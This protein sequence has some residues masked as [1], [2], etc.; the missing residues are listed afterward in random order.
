VAID[1]TETFRDDV[2][3]TNGCIKRDGL[4]LRPCDNFHIF[5]CISCFIDPIISRTTVLKLKEVNA[6][7]KVVA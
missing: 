6:K 1:A 7:Y 5:S 4:D 3:V 2:K